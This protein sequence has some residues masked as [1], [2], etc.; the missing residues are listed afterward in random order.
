MLTWKSQV[1]RD[2]L[3]N[4]IQLEVRLW[5]ASKDRDKCRLHRLEVAHSNVREQRGDRKAWSCWVEG[6]RLE[7]LWTEQDWKT[8][9]A[10]GHQN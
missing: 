8:M 4:E 1:G 3:A 7:D 2:K 9:S 5:R 6:D 10:K